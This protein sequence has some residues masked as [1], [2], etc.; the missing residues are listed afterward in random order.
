M[1]TETNADE[2]TGEGALS[3]RVKRLL[4]ERP[5]GRIFGE[6]GFEPVSLVELAQA[7]S[8]REAAA[9][10]GSAA[11]LA[12]RGFPVVGVCGT[13]NAGKSTL[14]AGFLSDSGRERVLT[15]DDSTE[16][17]TFW[18][19][20]ESDARE[21]H[22]ELL[23]RSVREMLECEPQWLAETPEQAL[24]QQNAQGEESKIS[25]LETPLVACDPGLVEQGIGFLDCPDIQKSAD[26]SV[27]E[28]TA[29]LRL[30]ALRKFSRACSAF[31]VVTTDEGIKI[32]RFGEIFR[33][34][35]ETGSE[36]RIILVYNK[37]ATGCDRDRKLETV[38]ELTK[39]W[40]ESRVVGIFG[41][42]YE[43]GKG[44]HPRF[45]DLQQPERTL[46][47]F[48][49]ELTPSNL[50]RNV[51][52][53]ALSEL[54]E[55]VERLPDQVE[56]RQAP[57]QK[58]VEDVHEALTRFL[59]KYFVNPKGNLRNLVT[60][61]QHA[62]ELLESFIR[63]AP[64][65][66]TKWAFK[67]ASPIKKLNELIAT[68]GKAVAKRAHAGIAPLLAWFN[69]LQPSKFLKIEPQDVGHK[70][71]P[72]DFR[73]VMQACPFH[74]PES[75]EETYDAIFA[76]SVRSVSESHFRSGFDSGRLDACA[77]QVWK[78][79]PGWK[80]LAFAFAFPAL[81]TVS[82]V[83]ALLFTVI[84][85]TG[86]TSV[87][88]ANLLEILSGSVL[89]YLVASQGM[90]MLN[91]QLEKDLAIPQLGDL[92]AL[93]SDQLGIPRAEKVTL[94]PKG[95]EG[96]KLFP[97]Q[98]GMDRVPP[99]LNLLQAPLIKLDHDAVNGIL[100]ELEQLRKEEGA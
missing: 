10:K 91:A 56:Q 30:E 72:A 25:Q 68:G 7:N 86:A 27:S 29:N 78:N 36:L 92:H 47:E 97:D 79:V 77:E 1:T 31:I 59:G 43:S 80:R 96:K 19:P 100:S 74:R 54:V 90:A 12:Q 52:A 46:A 33:L 17:F 37:L 5:C 2:T 99:L 22:N 70:I 40:K 42:E 58:T 55:T 69:F 85:P 49:R 20:D 32:E 16:R 41:A 67:L 75:D 95:G 26:E 28:S 64:G 87:V 76:S 34:L 53:S 98:S 50:F 4:F 3:Q 45:F 88:A 24:Q 44:N 8:P 6:T 35:K 62:K 93:L 66:A 63:T 39:R 83:I 38:R 94:S 9:L 60:P 81:V 57:L 13:I 18:L 15:G 84:D 14:V 61:P 11:R 51:H 23:L 65:R 48:S 89:S 21:G 73:K 71:R 82:V